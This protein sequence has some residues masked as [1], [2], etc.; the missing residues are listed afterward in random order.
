MVVL[1]YK[2]I[3]SMSLDASLTHLGLTP[4]EAQLYLALLQLGT[5]NVSTI[6]K[7]AD[8]K[9]PTAYVLLDQMENK[10]VV[11]QTKSGKE[12]LYTPVNP[13]QLQA[14]LEV[15]LADF[16][17]ALPR[18]K[19]LVTTQVGRPQVSVIEGKGKMIE[20]WYKGGAQQGEILFITDIDTL[21]AEFDD[22]LSDFIHVLRR[23][24]HPYR[25]LIGASRASRKYAR[26]AKRDL[27]FR[28]VR[29]MDHEPTSDIMIYA[30][31]VNISSYRD[32]NFYV[33]S[34]TNQQ[35]ADTYRATFEQAWKSAKQVR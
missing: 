21:A 34:I 10:G 8:V 3:D 20:T 16:T 24:R 1:C 13:E 33:V 18:L 28:Q 23:T 22:F 2:I 9:R 4:K 17:A 7:Q 6:A 12:K 32:N 19:A 27:P 5:A 11:T 30:D 35:I 14:S 26:E 29:L 15:Q 31:T 25:E